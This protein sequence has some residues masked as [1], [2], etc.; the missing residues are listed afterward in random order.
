MSTQGKGPA[1]KAVEPPVRRTLVIIPTYN[2]L[3]NLPLILDRVHK[4]RPDVHVLVVDDSSPDGTGDLA[5]ERALA[6]PY[7]EKQA[8]WKG[9][10]IGLFIVAGIILAG[11]AFMAH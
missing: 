6:D 1:K 10:V 2:E 9:I 5:D 3:E 4:A 8:P 11:I 7:A